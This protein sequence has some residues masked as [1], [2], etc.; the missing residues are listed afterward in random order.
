MLT[1][2][3]IKDGR[4]DFNWVGTPI[5]VMCFILDGHSKLSLYRTYMDLVEDVDYYVTD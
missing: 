2:R 5:S 4:I 1:I 3:R